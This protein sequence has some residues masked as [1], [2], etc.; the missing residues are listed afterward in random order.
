MHQYIEEQQYR[1][2]SP[3][4]ESVS[5]DVEKYLGIAVPPTAEFVRKYL[6]KYREKVLIVR[7]RAERERLVA[8]LTRDH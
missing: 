7:N 6:E 4:C 1:T 5:K 3:T 2:E 8:F